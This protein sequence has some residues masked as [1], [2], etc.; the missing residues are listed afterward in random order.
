[1]TYEEKL[2]DAGR[3][4]DVDLKS[5]E[6]GLLHQGGWLAALAKRVDALEQQEPGPDPDPCP[7]PDPDPEPDE[8][9]F[10]DG[11]DQYGLTPSI[12][13]PANPTLANGVP[14]TPEMRRTYG[15]FMHAFLNNREGWGSVEHAFGHTDVQV[16]CREASLFTSAGLGAYRFTRDRR[17]LD[18][19][20]EGFD[21]LDNNMRVGW[22][23]HDCGLIDARTTESCCGNGTPWAPGFRI[24][25]RE[26]TADWRHGTDLRYGYEFQLRGIMAL[27][28]WTM[29][30]SRGAVSPAGRDYRALADYWG[31]LA[32]QFVSVY[33]ADVNECWA[34][35]NKRGVA[36]GGGFHSGSYRERA[37]WGEWPI[38]WQTS[39][40]IDTATLQRYLGALGDTGL[41]DIPN[42]SRALESAHAIL[43]LWPTDWI[44]C[45]DSRG[46]Q[47]VIL[48]GAHLSGSRHGAPL[49][50]TYTGSTAWQ[51]VTQALS[52][53]YRVWTPENLARLARSYADMTNPDGTLKRN[54]AAEVDRCNHGLDVTDGSDTPLS[55]T[56]R[57]AHAM[58]IFADEGDTRLWDAA[59]ATQESGSARGY[60]TPRRGLNACAQFIRLAMEAP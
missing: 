57:R 44:E 28:A 17:I 11:F 15:A 35:A 42:P 29:H 22:R 2:A 38:A 60:D 18:R 56:S 26:S 36:A 31:G 58:L 39:I 59:T 1:M 43:D 53:A 3:K 19:L 55:Q 13:D 8:G 27:W 9:E 24:L 7:D 4:L 30:Q 32:E 54:L 23:G 46:R 50:S 20:A 47:S 40:T 14:F 6:D 48:R 33:S 45:V 49:R 16:A 21:I 52:G 41:W 51:I 25:C 10:A 37:R 5:I 12:F 34:T